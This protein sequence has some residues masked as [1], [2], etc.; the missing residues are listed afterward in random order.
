MRTQALSFRGKGCVREFMTD[1]GKSYIILG[2][3]DESALVLQKVR[4]KG[5]AVADF[6]PVRK[7]KQILEKLGIDKK[8]K[9]TYQMAWEL[10]KER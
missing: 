5:E 7:Q 1:D 9:N 3:P 4:G 2:F 10:L 8:G 6:N